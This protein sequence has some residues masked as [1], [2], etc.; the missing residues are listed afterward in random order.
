VSLVSRVVG[1]LSVLVAVERPVQ[2]WQT[3]RLVWLCRFSCRGDN[4]LRGVSRL[5][6]SCSGW[7]LA[8]C[9]GWLHCGGGLV[10][11]SRGLCCDARWAVVVLDNFDLR[12]G[13][14]GVENDKFVDGAG[15]D[16]VGPAAGNVEA[17][18]ELGDFDVLRLSDDSAVEVEGGVA[19]AI[20]SEGQVEPLVN[21]D[22][23]GPR[24]GA[25]SAEKCDS[26]GLG[27]EVELPARN[28]SPET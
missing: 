24:D 26:A 14:R 21:V 16:T 10:S 6:A 1:A 7:L 5:L 13:Q 18:G 11:C 27:A 15:Q 28:Q 8:R 25:E 3:A 17:S 9:S 23:D 19:L 20:S 12:Y 4:N 2:P 22:I